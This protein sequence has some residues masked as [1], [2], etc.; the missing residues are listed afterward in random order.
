[1]PI[2]YTGDYLKD[3]EAANYKAG[4][5]QKTTPSGY[6]WHHLDDYNPETNTA[7]MQLVKRNAHQGISHVGGASQYKAATGRAYTFPARKRVHNTAG[8]NC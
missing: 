2:E 3:F 5:N 6:T 1:M 7:T 4:L 8:E